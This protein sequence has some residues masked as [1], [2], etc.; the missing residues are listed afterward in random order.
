D[1]LTECLRIVPVTAWLLCSLQPNNLN[2]W[3]TLAYCYH[4]IAAQMFDEMFASPMKIVSEQYNVKDISFIK[5][6]SKDDAKLDE[7]CYFWLY[8]FMQ[9]DYC[10]IT[11][12]QMYDE[13]HL[14]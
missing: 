5:N 1:T 7:S 12:L 11:A 10:Y 13:V 3:I 2:A 8:N 6:K 4:V 9:A 14:K